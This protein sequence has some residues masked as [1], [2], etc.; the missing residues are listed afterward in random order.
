MSDRRPKIL[1]P[2]DYSAMT[3]QLLIDY[4]TAHER[5]F[6]SFLVPFLFVILLPVLDAFS[7]YHSKYP[8]HGV[9]EQF[10]KLNNF[11]G[12]CTTYAGY[13]C[14]IRLQLRDDIDE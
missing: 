7:L 13:L 14:Q 1:W 10:A 11:D 4:Y 5:H 8:S 3:H 12:A 9:I 2:I 6:S